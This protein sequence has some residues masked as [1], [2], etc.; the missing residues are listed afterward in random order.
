MA[1]LIDTAMIRKSSWNKLRKRGEVT[2][3]LLGKMPE[4]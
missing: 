4:A 3:V 2:T 1:S